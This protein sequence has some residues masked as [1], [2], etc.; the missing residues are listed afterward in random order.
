MTPASSFV[1]FEPQAP[2]IK[3]AGSSLSASKLGR[4]VS[5]VAE[6]NEVDARLSDKLRFFNHK[7]SYGKRYFPMIG[8][9][10][11]PNHDLDLDV[12]VIG[13]DEVFN[14]VQSNTN[15]G[16]SRDLF[17][18]GSPANRLISYAGSFGN[19]T[20]EKI[21]AAGIRQDLAED[22]ARF[23]AISVRDR[24]SAQIVE[25]LT[26]QP[27]EVHVDPVLAYD[28]MNLETRIPE[29]RQYDAKYIIVY[30]YS[31]RFDH[32]ENQ[33]LKRYAGS[34]GADDPVRR[35]RPGMLRSLHRLQ[36]DRVARILP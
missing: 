11:E 12:Q 36:P 10:A 7:R 35:R 14:C 28:Y 25:Q 6:Y 5:K 21:E 32:E 4:V 22:F 31:G 18:H 2:L 24:N 20:I 16:Y 33:I 1:D 34:I 8:V 29:Q 30:G 3:E 17:G 13:S 23:S 19:T 26:G 27:P 9:T 15:V